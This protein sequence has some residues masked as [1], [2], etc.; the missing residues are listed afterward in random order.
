MKR[1]EGTSWSQSRKLGRLGNCVRSTDSRDVIALTVEHRGSCRGGGM[2]CGSTKLH[3]ELWG[4]ND[5]G[6]TGYLAF[7]SASAARTGVLFV[8]VE[9][10]E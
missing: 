1:A 6:G 7:S 2:R 5:A 3:L 10:S 4:H 9:L 8:R